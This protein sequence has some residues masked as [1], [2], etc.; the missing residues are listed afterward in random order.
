MRARLQEAGLGRCGR[1]GRGARCGVR[2]GEG[3]WRGRAGTRGKGAGV[4]GRG[5]RAL[6]AE[7]SDNGGDLF[8]LL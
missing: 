8:E 4:P 1:A 3:V 2:A 6:S 7:R 5:V